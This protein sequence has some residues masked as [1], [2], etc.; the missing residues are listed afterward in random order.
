MIRKKRQASNQFTSTNND[1]YNV[2]SD[3][4]KAPSNKKKLTN[5]D[6]GADNQNAPS[7]LKNSNVLK[8]TNNH[9]KDGSKSTTNETKDVGSDD[10]KA[11]SNKKTKR[12]QKHQRPMRKMAL[13]SRINHQ[14]R[15][16]RPIR[17]PLLLPRI[18]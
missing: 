12:N 15:K 5:M 3:D 2:P 1:T 16:R 9:T 8:S 17:L 7:N 13:L 14:R 18:L 4:E 11:S 10:Q 6:D